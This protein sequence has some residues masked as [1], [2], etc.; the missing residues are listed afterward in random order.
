VGHFELVPGAL[1]VELRKGPIP[2]LT[3]DRTSNS[4]SE[5][6]VMR[7]ERVRGLVADHF[8]FISRTV[9][10]LG[11]GLDEVEDAVQEVF[12]VGARRLDSVASGAERSFLFATAL[13][14]VSTRRRNAGR[15]RTE[16]RASLDDYEHPAQSPEEASALGQARELLQDILMQMPLEQRTVFILFELEELAVPEIAEVVGVPAGTVNSRLRAARE[17]FRAAAERLKLH[18]AFSVRGS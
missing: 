4:D 11:V 6:A 7:D 15:R 18:D 2:P 9:R 14:I 17:I 8:D 12:M 1:T 10:R 13:R 16:A 5:S 3:R